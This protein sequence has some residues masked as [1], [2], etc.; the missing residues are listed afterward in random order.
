MSRVVDNRKLTA[1]QNYLLQR[2]PS[3]YQLNGHKPTPETAEL[4]RARKLIERW[5][6]TEAL[7]ECKAKK[8][9]EALITKAREAVYFSTPEKALRI[10]QQCEK[11]LKG[12]PVG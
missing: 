7:R 9:N 2:I 8:R 11:L 4:K 6:K 1:Q 10:V 5:D 12:C 3:S